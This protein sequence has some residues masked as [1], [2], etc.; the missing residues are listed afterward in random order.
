MGL[1]DDCQNKGFES[2]S[3]P[4]GALNSVWHRLVWHL[5]R[6]GIVTSVRKGTALIL[7]RLAEWLVPG[8][9]PRQETQQLPAANA[10]PS[11]AQPPDTEPPLNLQP[12]DWVEVK[13]EAEILHTLDAAGRSQGLVFMPARAEYCGRRVRVLKR[14]DRIILEHTGEVRKLKRTVLLEGA[15]CA[16]AGQRCDRG[17]FYF[18]RE[19]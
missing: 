2:A 4:A 1:N 16:G 19:A 7:R 17:C 15:I 11:S 14:V 9:G 10:T 3:E 12:G 5:R 13:S 6:E 18:W 8:H